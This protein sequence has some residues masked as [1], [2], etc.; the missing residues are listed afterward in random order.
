VHEHAD[1]FGALPA[2]VHEGAVRAY[3][4][5]ASH[6]GLTPA[7]A[8]M[9]VAPWLGPDGQQAFYRQ[10][11]RPIRPTPTRLSRATPSLNFPC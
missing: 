5:S 8:D 1:V 10:I 4:A 3:V 11:A 6:T 9:L 7:Q 2:T